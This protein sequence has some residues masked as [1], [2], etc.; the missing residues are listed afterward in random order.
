MQHLYSE[1][2]VIKV[3]IKKGTKKTRS[4]FSRDKVLLSF[5]YATGARAQE[6]CDFKVAGLRINA[7]TASVTL[8]GKGLKS[9]QVGILYIPTR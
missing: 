7:G 9:L 6:I 3:P 4:V 5:M 2:A 1:G 8:V